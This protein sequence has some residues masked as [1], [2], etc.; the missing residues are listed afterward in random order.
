M[1]FALHNCPR[2]GGT[3]V[4]RY[5]PR[6]NRGCRANNMDYT[7]FAKWEGRG[8]THLHELVRLQQEVPDRIVKIASM[9]TRKGVL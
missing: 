3:T 7:S 6:S 8:F 2:W 4:N 1:L 5:V 9:L